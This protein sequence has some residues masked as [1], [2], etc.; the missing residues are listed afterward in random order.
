MDPNHLITTG[1]EG[2]FDES[3]PMARYNPQDRSLWASRT[4]QHFRANHAH[5]AISYATVHTWPDNWRNPPFPTSWGRQWLDAHSQVF[6]P[7]IVRVW[8]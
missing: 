2:F 1:A 8:L 7:K 4:G 5:A 6:K 3:D